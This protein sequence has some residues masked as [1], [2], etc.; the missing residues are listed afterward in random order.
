M[1]DTTINHKIYAWGLFT[2]SALPDPRS[3]HWLPRESCRKQL[4]QRVYICLNIYG[5]EIKNLVIRGWFDNIVMYTYLLCY[6]ICML[7]YTLY[8]SSFNAN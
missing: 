8:I 5:V 2:H 3:E 1:D 7:L 6:V 4:E